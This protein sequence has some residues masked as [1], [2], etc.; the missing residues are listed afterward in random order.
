MNLFRLP[1][2]ICLFI[3][4]ALATSAAGTSP[5]TK[6]GHN[7]PPAFETNVGQARFSNDVDGSYVDAVIRVNGV[8]AYV[9]KG[10]SPHA[11]NSN[12]Q[13]SYLTKT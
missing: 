11:P 8:M 2:L 13:G 12:L 9:H 3:A 5:S 6:K 10:G 4:I 1:F 7:T